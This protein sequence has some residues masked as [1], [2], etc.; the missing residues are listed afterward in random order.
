MSDSISFLWEGSCHNI[1]MSR[2]KLLLE[3]L[4]LTFQVLV[5]LLPFCEMKMKFWSVIKRT[6]LNR[7]LLLY[8]IVLSLVL[9]CYNLFSF[10]KGI[11]KLIN[12]RVYIFFLFLFFFFSPFVR[13]ILDRET[14]SLKLSFHS[15]FQQEI[16]HE[17]QLFV[18]I[19]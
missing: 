9:L 5:E 19:C 1:K 2:K 6:I 15:W 8:P 3:K 17:P 10:P 12:H 4:N 14:V 16:Q 13:L 7:S 11:L 18:T